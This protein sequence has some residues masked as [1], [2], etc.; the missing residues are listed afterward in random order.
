MTR[1]ALAF[2]FF[3]VFYLIGGVIP[4]HVLADPGDS[5]YV[6]VNSTKLRREPKHWSTPLASLNFGDKLE[7]LAFQTG[8][9]RV[10]SSKTGTA[11]NNPA[12]RDGEGYVHESAV[13]ARSVILKSGGSVT[14]IKPDESDIVLAG[15]GFNSDVESSYSKQDTPLNYAAVDTVVNKKIDARELEEFLRAG[16]LN[17]D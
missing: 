5:L 12:L 6:E 14:D 8:W 3:C 9:F 15:K 2:G 10:K 7:E 4:P 1:L 16:K 13:T 11:E 17:S